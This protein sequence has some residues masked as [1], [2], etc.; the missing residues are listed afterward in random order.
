MTGIEEMFA[1]LDG[2]GRFWSDLEV[3]AA[4][5]I[6]AR[7]AHHADPWS[8]RAAV[9]RTREWRKQNPERARALRH[10][11]VK[12]WRKRNP[13]KVRAIK[14]GYRDRNRDKVRETWRRNTAA[15]RARRKAKG[16]V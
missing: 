5:Q 13:D 14:Q 15:Y 9:I 16:F 1:E 3:W 2:Y 4:K 7:I 6:A 12:A 11:S 8:R 10:Q